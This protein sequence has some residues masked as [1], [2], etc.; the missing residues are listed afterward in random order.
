MNLMCLEVRSRRRLNS[1]VVVL[2]PF[3]SEVLVHLNHENL[4]QIRLYPLVIA[5]T[6]LSP[7]HPPDP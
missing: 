6:S 2:I 5:V 7:H 4:L 1:C 3:S